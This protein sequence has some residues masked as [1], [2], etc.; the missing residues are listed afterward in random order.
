MVALNTGC[1]YKFKFLV[2]RP[3]SFDT[4]SNRRLS[5]AKHREN[6]IW[7]VFVCDLTGYCANNYTE[8]TGNTVMMQIL[9]VASR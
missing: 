1:F 5:N 6:I 2:T 9:L 8:V 7:S 4:A 3:D